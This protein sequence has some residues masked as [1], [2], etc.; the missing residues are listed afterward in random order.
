MTAKLVIE[1]DKKLHFNITTFDLGFKNITQS[2]VD[3][4][5]A[6]SLNKVV[7]LFKNLLLDALNGLGTN[8]ISIEEVL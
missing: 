3:P 8:G 4:V 7:G 6:E 2:E 1:E 5:S